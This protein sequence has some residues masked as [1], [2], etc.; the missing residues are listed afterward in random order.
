MKVGSEECDDANQDSN[1]GCDSGCQFEAGFNCDAN[2][3]TVCTPICGDGIVV[4]TEIC[5]DG[6]DDLE[7]C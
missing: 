7:G 4:G 3:P 2:L 5:D 6:L 1:D